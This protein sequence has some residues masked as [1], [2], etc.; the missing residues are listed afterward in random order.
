MD[1]GYLIIITLVFTLLLIVVQRTESGRRKLSLMLFVII[2]LILRHN[3][4]VRGD[5]H[6]ETLIA[7]IVSLVL[8]FLFWLF[9][10]RYNPV[11]S[12]DSIQV[13]GMDD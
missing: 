1:W 12:S 7:V 11:G 4:F 5:V 10:G 13:I 9:I 3:A 2:V 8:S 6:E